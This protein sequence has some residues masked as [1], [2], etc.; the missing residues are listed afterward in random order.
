M[1]N[2]CVGSL[3]ATP[4]CKLQSWVQIQQSPQPIV[5][6][7]SLDWLPSGMAL[8]CML[9]SEGRQRSIHKNKKITKNNEGKKN[10][11]LAIWRVDVVKAVFI[12]LLNVHQQVRPKSVSPCHP[13]PSKDFTFGKQFQ[14]KISP[15][16]SDAIQPLHLSGQIAAL[17]TRDGS[18]EPFHVL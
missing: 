15:L 17:F 2:T 10:F 3:V 4:D 13:S 8:C 11:F 9:S 12:Y 5:D 7:Q 1:N 18:G 6:C 16:S 14:S